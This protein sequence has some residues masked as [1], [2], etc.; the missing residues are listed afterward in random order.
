MFRNYFQVGVT[1]FGIDFLN[2]AEFIPQFVFEI[3]SLLH[4]A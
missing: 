2:K 1:P 3:V 4:Y